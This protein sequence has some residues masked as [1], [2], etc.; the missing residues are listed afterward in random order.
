M[1]NNWIV[2]QMCTRLPAFPVG[3]AHSSD[4]CCLTWQKKNILS[5]SCMIH[6]TMTSQQAERPLK[7]IRHSLWLSIFHCKRAQLFTMTLFGDRNKERKD[8]VI[9]R[10][11][12]RA[13]VCKVLQCPLVNMLYSTN[14]SLYICSLLSVICG[15]NQSCRIESTIEGNNN[16]HFSLTFP[17]NYFIGLKSFG[18]H[19]VHCNI[20]YRWSSFSKAASFLSNKAGNSFICHCEHLNTWINM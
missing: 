16:L 7:C 13:R 8:E 11:R 2:L 4:A 5:K 12:E 15:T 6:K 3:L 14:V 9:G 19:Y 10:E 18:S 1:S 20:A 17:L